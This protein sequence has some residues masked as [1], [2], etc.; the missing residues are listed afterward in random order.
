MR[1]RKVRG[2]R[3]VT[4]ERIEG[5]DGAIETF[6]PSVTGSIRVAVGLPYCGIC[7]PVRG[8]SRDLDRC[9]NR[10]MLC[11]CC[12]LDAA[13]LVVQ[14]QDDQH[15]LYAARV[16]WAD[17]GRWRLRCRSLKSGDGGAWPKIARQSPS[18]AC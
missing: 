13:I 8:V 1:S 12:L 9:R 18:C 4:S 6:H 16:L 15:K 14:L 7:R 2:R 3:S 17:V 10:P 11:K 5:M